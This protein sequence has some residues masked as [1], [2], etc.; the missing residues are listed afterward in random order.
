[1]APRR[2]PSDAALAIAATA[3]NHAHTDFS[4]YQ[5]GSYMFGIGPI[6]PTFTYR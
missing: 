1:M 2:T 3:S 6:V 4:S 5:S